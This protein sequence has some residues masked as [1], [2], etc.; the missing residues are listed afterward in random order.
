M[1]LTEEQD[2]RT[3]EKPLFK[4]HLKLPF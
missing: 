1:R 2:A 3:P 4:R